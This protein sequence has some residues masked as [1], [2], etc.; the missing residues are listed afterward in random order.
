VL[1][2][3]LGTVRFADEVK[4]TPIWLDEPNPHANVP[5]CDHGSLPDSVDTVVIGAG[6]TG[7]GCAY[8]WARLSMDR[9]LAVL[10]MGDPA[11]G[12]SGRNEGVVVMGRYAA[13]VRDTV[14][15][16]LDRVRTDL[17]AA[18][19]Q[20]LSEQFASVYAQAGYHERRPGGAHGAGRG[21][22]L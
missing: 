16:Y 12:A 4:R 1:P 3:A 10:D 8:H 2:Q 18:D 20:R 19:R 5:W 14:R 9:S 11:S 21:V 15:A 22:F 13:M 6:F 17:S 7:A